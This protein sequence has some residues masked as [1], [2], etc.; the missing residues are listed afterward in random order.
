MK[1]LLIILGTILFIGA[2]LFIYAACKVASSVE[3]D[4]EEDLERIRNEYINKNKKNN[5]KK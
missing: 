4:Y 5:K 2:L 1:I 3:H